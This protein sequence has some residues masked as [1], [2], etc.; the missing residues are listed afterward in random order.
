MYSE[1]LEETIMTFFI[2][3]SFSEDGFLC[4]F[5]IS[6]VAGQCD[7]LELFEKEGEAR[8]CGHMAR[9]NSCSCPDADKHRPRTFY[10]YSPLQ[11]KAYVWE[12]V[13]CYT[14][15]RLVSQDPAQEA[16]TIQSHRAL[17]ERSIKDGSLMHLREKGSGKHHEL[18]IDL[19]PT[20][21]TRVG[22]KRKPSGQLTNLPSWGDIEEFWDIPPT[23]PPGG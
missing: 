20:D 10:M 22:L 3:R 14:C 15:M 8:S 16:V 1:P 23:P 11:R 12:A 17:Q 2:G 19:E 21:D 4:E 7:A 18:Y 13:V 5:F 6:R 9:N